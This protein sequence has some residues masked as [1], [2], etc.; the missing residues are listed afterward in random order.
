[1][2]NQTPKD[3]SILDKFN[4]EIKPVGV[5]FTSVKPKGLKP[6]EQTLDFC[7]MLAE[8]QK[9]KAFYAAQDNITC[10]GTATPGDGGRKRAF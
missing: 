5:K 8:A 9:G 3:L 6:P 4:F 7:E 2:M 10:L 1:M